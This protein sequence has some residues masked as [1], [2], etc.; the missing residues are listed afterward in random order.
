[1]VTSIATIVLILVTVGTWKRIVVAPLV[2]LV[3][4]SVAIA[5]VIS[6]GKIAVIVLIVPLM[7]GFWTATRGIAALK[8]LRREALIQATQG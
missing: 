1:M 4:A 2:G 5:W 8:R 7:G 3:V 6:H